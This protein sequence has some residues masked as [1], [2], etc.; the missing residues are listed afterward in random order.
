MPSLSL[1]LGT[2]ASKITKQ[3]SKTGLARTGSLSG[4]FGWMQQPRSNWQSQMSW[5]SSRSRLNSS[6]EVKSGDYSPLADRN[7]LMV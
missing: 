4:H 2:K 5:V 3:P 7:H 1:A 6:R